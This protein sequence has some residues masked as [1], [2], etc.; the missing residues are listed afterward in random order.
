MDNYQTIWRVY[1][2]PPYDKAEPDWALQYWDVGY[3]P[4]GLSCSDVVNRFGQDA[5]KNDWQKEPGKAMNGFNGVSSGW[6]Q[7]VVDEDTGL[8]YIPSTGNQS[9]YT[10]VT[11]RPGPN[12]YGSTI[13]A[14]DLN[15][16]AL[17]WWLQPLPHD[18]WDYDCN[19]GGILADVKGIGKVFAKGCKEGILYVMDAATGK[20]AYWVDIM[21]DNPQPM[22]VRTIEIPDPSTTTPKV[23][24]KDSTGKEYKYNFAEW[25]KLPWPG[26]P[27]NPQIAMNQPLITGA[28]QV[29]MSYDPATQTLFHYYASGGRT[30]LKQG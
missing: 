14:I 30:I 9:P 22:G 18:S 3:S 2:N 1:L 12:L 10:N 17:K 27:N 25:I 8:A 20:P 15:K 28:F 4:Y 19:W 24:Y 21:K 16:G 5:L 29:D 7:I 6:G 23:L 26:Y 11:F 13:L